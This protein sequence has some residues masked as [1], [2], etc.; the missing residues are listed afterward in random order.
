MRKYLPQ[1][2]EHLN[3]AQSNCFSFRMMPRPTRLRPNRNRQVENISVWS[4]REANDGVLFPRHKARVA[5][6]SRCNELGRYRLGT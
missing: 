5:T 1:Q 2:G 3:R 6:S 4:I